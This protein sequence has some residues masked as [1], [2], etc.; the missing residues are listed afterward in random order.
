M[1]LNFSRLDDVVRVAM[2]GY[3]TVVVDHPDALYTASRAVLSRASFVGIICTPDISALYPVRRKRRAIAALLAREPNR[4][5]L[6]VNRSTSWGSLDHADVERAAEA[7]I[8]AALPND[9]AAVRRASWQG[10]L[11]QQDSALAVEMLKLAER[12]DVEAPQSVQVPEVAVGKEVR[13]G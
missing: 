9:Y 12:I 11:I 5:G 13:N 8:M 2:E 7:P 10:G 3:S 6:I 4:L 1:P